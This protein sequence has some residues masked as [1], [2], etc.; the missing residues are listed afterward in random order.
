MAQ[1]GIGGLK[2]HSRLEKRPHRLP[3]LLTPVVI[4][5]KGG[6]GDV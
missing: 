2:D 5:P 3:V 6:K 4:N 1:N